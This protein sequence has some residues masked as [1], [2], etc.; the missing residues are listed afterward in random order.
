MVNWLV[1]LT[2]LYGSWVLWLGLVLTILMVLVV[3]CLGYLYWKRDEQRS[4][5]SVLIVIGCSLTLVLALTLSKTNHVLHTIKPSHYVIYH[6]TK[7]RS[8]ENKIDVSVKGLTDPVMI[9]KSQVEHE[10]VE[11]HSMSEMGKSYAK[12]KLLESNVN[13]LSIH[14]LKAGPL[15]KRY[16]DL[17]RQ[18]KLIIYQHDDPGKLNYDQVLNW[19]ERF[20]SKY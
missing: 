20:E 15:A 11:S 4:L 17:K 6:V 8:R 18:S 12:L 2:F 5:L 13:G 3:F 10:T 9:S 1:R 14:Q 7:I 19:V 16:P